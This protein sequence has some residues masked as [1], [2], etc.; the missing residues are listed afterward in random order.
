MRPVYKMLLQPV[1][2]L[3]LLLEGWGNSAEQKIIPRPVV[4]LFKRKEL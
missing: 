4:L 2:I 1:D 3:C